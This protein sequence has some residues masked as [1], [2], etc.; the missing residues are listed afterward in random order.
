M[1]TV[2]FRNEVRH[3]I[4]VA[5]SCAAGGPLGTVRRRASGV[6]VRLSF[7]NWLAPS[8]YTLTP[9]VAEYLGR[10]AT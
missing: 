4:F 6:S 5:T 1:F 7:E 3:T 2:T 9:A 8:R 10:R